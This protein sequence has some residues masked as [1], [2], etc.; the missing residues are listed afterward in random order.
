MTNRN[1]IANRLDYLHKRTNSFQLRAVKT[2]WKPLM[3]RLLQSKLFCLRALTCYAALLLLGGVLPHQGWAQADEN[4]PVPPE[5]QPARRGPEDGLRGRLICRSKIYN[6]TERE[7][8]IYVPAQYLPE[9]PACTLIVQDGLSR[10]QGWNLPQICDNLI[11]M[12]EM[13]V[14]IGIL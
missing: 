8:W 12:Q 10:A 2:A 14:T 11:H 6:G 5:A 4:Y 9:K 3:L 1:V 7:Y 13:P